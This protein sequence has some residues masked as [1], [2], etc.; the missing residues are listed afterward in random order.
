MSATV[1]R[2]L[3]PPLPSPPVPGFWGLVHPVS[4]VPRPVVN[5]VPRFSPWPG[6]M[7]QLTPSTRPASAQ[8]ELLMPEL[9]TPE[10]GKVRYF[11]AMLPDDAKASK[12]GVSYHP[13]EIL[14]CA[15][16]LRIVS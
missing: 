3:L 11:D 9:T 7:W 12:A 6:I 5:G 16:G 10:P 2:L 1:P 8:V 13:L 14:V 4:C 15:L